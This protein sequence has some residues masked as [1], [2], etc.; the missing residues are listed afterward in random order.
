MEARRK[1]GADF[2]SKTVL[3]DKNLLNHFLDHSSARAS[4]TEYVPATV[5]F[6]SSQ[7]HLF[8]LLAKMPATKKRKS[9]HD[10]G[11]DDEFDR[12]EL[13]PETSSEGVPKSFQ[14]LGVI[15]S[16]CEACDRLGYK[17]PTPIQTAAIPPA[18]QGRDIIGLAETGSGKTAAFVLPI[19]QGASDV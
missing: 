13:M 17:A 2:M 8:D 14:D 1:S 3:I 18:L 7:I 15:E 16:L 5:H 12:A 11:S 19:L 10:S 4:F 9:S 6:S